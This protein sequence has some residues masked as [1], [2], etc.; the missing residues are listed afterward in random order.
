MLLIIL[1]KKA[2]QHSGTNETI[3]VWPPSNYF[4]PLSV[5]SY[6]HHQAVVGIKW[7]PVCEMPRA[8]AGT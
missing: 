4:T 5:F 8:V 2:M 3:V 1:E 6:A 7:D